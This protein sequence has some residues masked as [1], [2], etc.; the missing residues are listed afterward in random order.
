MQRTNY[1]VDQRVTK[2]DLNY[3]ESSKALEI[4][5]QT[6]VELAHYT[7]LY[8]SST[9]LN[10]Q[11]QTID[12]SVQTSTQRG[13]G[14]G[15]YSTYLVPTTGSAAQIIIGRGWGITNGM[16]LIKATG[17]ITC[18]KGDNS[19]NSRW[20]STALSTMYVSLDYQ[21]SSSSV[22]NDSQGNVYY[23]RYDDSYMVNVSSVYPSGSNQLPIA[24]FTSDSGGNIVGS[25]FVDRRDWL[26]AIAVDESVMIK[27]PVADSMPTVY[28]H[29]HG[30]GSGTPSTTNPHAL[31]LFDL[32]GFPELINGIFLNDA[33]ATT[34]ASYTPSVVSPTSNAYIQFAPLFNGVAF[35][36]GKQYTNNIS[37]LSATGNSNG[38]YWVV[39]TA[40]GSTLVPSFVSTASVSFSNLV[41]QANPTML[42]FGS[43][44][45]SDN[46]DDISSFTDMH[47]VW[48]IS[49]ANLRADLDEAVANPSASIPAYSSLIDNF[50]RIRYQLG[51]A[52]NGTGSQWNGAHPLT[53][54]SASDA[55]A[56][57]TH[58][59]LTLTPIR[60]PIYNFGMLWLPGLTNGT[61]FGGGAA[62]PI[63]F[64]TALGAPSLTAP[65]TTLLQYNAIGDS[66]IPPAYPDNLQVHIIEDGYFK[67]G[68]FYHRL[69]KKCTAWEIVARIKR[70]S[71]TESARIVALIRKA[72][73]SSVIATLQ[74][75][76]D[77]GWNETSYTLKSKEFSFAT[78][79]M[80]TE[81]AAQTLVIV[82]VILY[83]AGSSGIDTYLTHCMIEEILN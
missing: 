4:Q 16:D 51:L 64:E 62:D 53:A 21:E 2:D 41:P 70:A 32:G 38:V 50:N 11:Q 3:T 74:D 52:L 71:S 46:G 59:S 47:R 43:A 45:I 48:L 67:L 1:H 33:S 44:T 18:N 19:F 40:S 8:S 79:S 5:Q 29:V 57:H 76:T 25:T 78:G 68:Q 30:L 42:L 63:A 24:Q 39:A 14:G 58:D 60:I 49:P 15:Y 80:T 72:S 55:D 37:P 10:F 34:I 13:V 17:S 20:I 36:N 75:S 77:L 9:P 27:D 54:G 66:V 73:D 6:A 12:A 31:T 35:V 61:K 82:D 7:Q 22:G 56:Y 65:A 28:D 26:R 23:K 69:N 83:S 81:I